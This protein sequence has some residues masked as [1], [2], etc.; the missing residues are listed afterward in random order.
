MSTASTIIAPREARGFTSF[1]YVLYAAV[2]LLWG[3]S[4]IALHM[5]LGVVAPEVSLFWRLSLIH[6]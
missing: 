3:T 6:I 2:V 1:D 5:Q 4:W